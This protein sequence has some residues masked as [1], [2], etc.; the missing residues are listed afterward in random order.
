[1]QKVYITEE[2]KTTLACPACE[3]S[4]TVDVS[5]CVKLARPVQIKIKCPC[6]H[7]YPATLE[8]RRH[9]RKA[10]NLKGTLSSQRG[11]ASGARGRMAVMDLSRSGVR[12]RLDAGRRIS[13]GD[14]LLVEFQLDD[15][16]HSTIRRESVVRRV[17]GLDL[18]AEFIPAASP[19]PGTKAM[20][21]Y[22]LP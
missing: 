20:G 22:L 17:D 2:H 16:Q 3:R 18:G 12:M 19:D 13:V 14:R 21:F 10:V 6:G 15:Q 11:D 9:F 5:A 4:R 7:Q 1:M 8:R